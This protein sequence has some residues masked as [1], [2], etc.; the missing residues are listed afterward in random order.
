MGSVRRVRLYA[1]HF[2]KGIAICSKERKQ[3]NQIANIEIIGDVKDKHVIII[4][5]MI[6]TAGTIC[7][8]ARLIRNKGAKSI[9]VICTHPILSGN[10]FEKID[11]SEIDKVVVSDTIPLKDSSKK[12]EVISIAGLIAEA[13]RK[14][15]NL[16][17]IGS[18][19]VF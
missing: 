11:H 4:D 13:I 14:I 16:E 1:N 10:A 9:E 6:D 12:I 17:G 5:D 8:A 2:E 15:H 19:F 3:A 7:K 18:L